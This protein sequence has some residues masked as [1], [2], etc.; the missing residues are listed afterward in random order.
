MAATSPPTARSS[1]QVG[2]AAQVGDHPAQGG[3]RGRVLLGGHAFLHL[4]MDPHVPLTGAHAAPLPLIAQGQRPVRRPDL[5][6]APIEVR[7][8]GY[9]RTSMGM[10]I[11]A[12][13]DDDAG[14]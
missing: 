12:G 3:D 6:S 5:P 10:D 1:G 8:E 2:V 4:R 14:V 9:I 13:V 11:S 7:V